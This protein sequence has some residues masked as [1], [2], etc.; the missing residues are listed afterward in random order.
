MTHADYV[1]KHGAGHQYF[2]KSMSS[3]GA[4]YRGLTPLV[5]MTAL[6]QAGTVVCEPIHRFRLEL[7]TDTLT[8]VMPA[9][10]HFRAVPSAQEVRGATTVLGGDIPAAQV[11]AL[12]QRVPALTRGEGGLESAFDRYEPMKDP[13]PSRPRTDDNPLDRKEY[14]LHVLRRV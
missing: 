4:D 14:L 3:T 8:A 5:L 11:H 10:A 13:H 1:G 6:K 9:L 2:N 7:P 12:Q